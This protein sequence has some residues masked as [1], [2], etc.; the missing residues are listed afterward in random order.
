[1][2][3]FRDA[4]TPTRWGGHLNVIVRIFVV[5]VLLLGRSA[6]GDDVSLVAAA[7]DLRFVLPD[8]VEQFTRETGHAVEVSY[9]SSGQFARQIENGAPF[10]LFLSADEQFVLRLIDGGHAPDRSYLYAV[11]RIVLFAPSGS[12]IDVDQ[13]LEGLKAMLADG[14]IA[15]FAIANPGHAPYG[16]AA[17]AALEGVGIWQQI[18]PR[19]VVAANAAQAAQFA[20]SGAT[21]GGII[22]LSLALAPQLAGAGRYSP[23]PRQLHA[24]EPLRQRMLLL[25]DAGEPAR[26]LYEY[27]QSPTAAARLQHYGFSAE[28]TSVD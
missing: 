12:V 7:S 20:A 10:E 16:R 4:D 23:I 27:L 13:G 9:G 24:V 5:L 1:M 19:L 11:G 25:D 22:P 18:E 14:V 6:Q 26:A 17:R 21:D 2:L 8:I 28:S 15:R 3:G